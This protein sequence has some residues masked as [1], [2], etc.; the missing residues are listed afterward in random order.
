MRME[1][2]RTCPL[3]CFT[4]SALNSRAKAYAFYSVLPTV[5]GVLCHAMLPMVWIALVGN[6]L[7]TYADSKMVYT[8]S[9]SHITCIVSGVHQ[10]PHQT[11]GYTGYNMSLCI[12]F[13]VTMLP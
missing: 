12:G 2:V 11:G 8:G 5:K 4:S 10:G 13:I 3:L 9:H 1:A 7:A 6:L